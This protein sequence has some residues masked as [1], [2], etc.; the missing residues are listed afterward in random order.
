MPCLCWPLC[1]FICEY[2]SWSFAFMHYM[3]S[4]YHNL[5]IFERMWIWTKLFILNVNTSDGWQTT[6]TLYILCAHTL[7]LCL[8][9]WWILALHDT[10]PCQEERER[11]KVREKASLPGQCGLIYFLHIFS[12]PLNLCRYSLYLSEGEHVSIWDWVIVSTSS[13]LFASLSL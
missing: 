4:D 7:C 2:V 6:T 13:N 5:D 9:L 8:V 12:Y 3:F 10:C 1:V 11:N